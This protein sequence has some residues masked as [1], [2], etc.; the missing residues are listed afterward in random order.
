[1]LTTAGVIQKRGASGTVLL[2]HAQ[3]PV[4]PLAERN[5]DFNMGDLTQKGHHRGEGRENQ[6]NVDVD[7]HLYEV[8]AANGL[9]LLGGTVQ[10]VAFPA[11]SQGAVHTSL[12]HG[13]Q[14]DTQAYYGEQLADIND[15]S[16]DVAVMHGRGVPRGL[17][18][19]Q[20]EVMKTYGPHIPF[21]QHDQEYY[22]PVDIVHKTRRQ[23]NV[24]EAH[25]LTTHGSGPSQVYP[26][27]LLGVSS[28][29]RVHAYGFYYRLTTGS[30]IDLLLEV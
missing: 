7:L 20:V 12:L 5:A 2:T 4:R 10:Q 19:S 9:H 30:T 1:M 27:Q 22:R 28:G 21:T 29:S 16:L 25:I 17:P 26:C 23:S 3:R 6:R 15:R 13:S 18:P 24:T 14:R 11:G 8:H